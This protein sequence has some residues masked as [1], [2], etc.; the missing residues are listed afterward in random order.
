MLDLNIRLARLALRR[1]DAAALGD[2][3]ERLREAEG[4]A[5]P[6][7]KVQILN[8]EGWFHRY[9]QPGAGIPSWETAEECW[10]KAASSPSHG[11][12][13]IEYERYDAY[14]NLYGLMF[15]RECKDK[16]IH[17]A[18]QLV[19]LTERHGFHKDLLDAHVARLCIAELDPLPVMGRQDATSI[20]D[21]AFE[22]QNP[23]ALIRYVIH[24]GGWAYV[25]KE[26]QLAFDLAACARTFAARIADSTHA[27]QADI[28]QLKI[29]GRLNRFEQAEQLYRAV[30]RSGYSDTIKIFA[31]FA[32]IKICFAAG[33]FDE[34]EQLLSE[35]PAGTYAETFSGLVSLCRLWARH[36]QNEPA[37]L[38]GMKSLKRELDRVDEEMFDILE[39]VGLHSSPPLFHVHAFGNLSFSQA[40]FQAPHWPRRKALSLLAHLTLRP[41]GCRPK[42]WR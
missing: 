25:L 7:Q 13:L 16:A 20:P 31:R 2:L 17:Y 19:A 24:M 4:E 5:S 42:L 30:L 37:A 18:E 14:L 34:A 10:L 8:L 11:D 27:G 29:F 6:L 36:Q 35:Q 26:F 23:L 15:N 32:W 40:G 21:E 41:E 28:I 1:K 22:C 33:R 38:E 39:R 3:M 12:R 9:F